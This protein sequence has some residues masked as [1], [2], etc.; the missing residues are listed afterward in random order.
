VSRAIDDQGSRG[1]GA[2]NKKLFGKIIAGSE[3]V[4]MLLITDSEEIR[5]LVTYV[6]FETF[7]DRW[8]VSGGRWNCDSSVAINALCDAGKGLRYARSWKASPA[9]DKS[10]AMRW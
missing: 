5:F 9:T 10:K 6:C 3:L 1:V 4:G 8:A 2:H 7:S